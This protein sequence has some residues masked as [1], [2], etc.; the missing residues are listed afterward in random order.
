MKEKK[1]IIFPWGLNQ[2]D[3]KAKQYIMNGWIRK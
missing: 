2:I 3:I 1:P